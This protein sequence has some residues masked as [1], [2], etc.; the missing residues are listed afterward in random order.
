MK[1]KRCRIADLSAAKYNPRVDLQP[2]DPVYDK[3]K[4][5]IETFGFVQP[6]IVN[7]RNKRV[8]GGHQR[9]KVLQDLGHD[10][11]DVGYVDLP[12][13]KEKA[14]NVTL[15][16]TVGGWD[17]T[18]LA[19]LLQEFQGLPDFDIELTGFDTNEVGD[20]ISRVLDRDAES[21][22]EDAFD[23]EAALDECRPAVTQSGEL[24][25]LGA[26]R[27]LCGDSTSGGA[28]RRQLR[29]RVRRPAAWRR[30]RSAASFARRSWP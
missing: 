12:V 4:K 13:A 28:Q 27:L 20:L 17:E 29:R 22:G 30:W 15:N 1:L 25:E 5:S 10:E 14:L 16:K 26:H 3:L 24:L 18:K 9:V 7:R 11:V 21:G 8:I 2:G 6:I 19:S 23:L